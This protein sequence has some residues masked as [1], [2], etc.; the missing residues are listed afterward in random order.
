M[1]SIQFLGLAS[2]TDW[3]S[4]I[5]QL[6]E[7]ERKP[8]EQLITQ[9]S[10]LLFNQSVMSSVNTRLGKFD[11]MLSSLRF[12]STFLSRNVETSNT[13]R[14][15]A[16]AEAG[17]AIGT[18]NVE[19]SRL[20]KAGRAASG[21][22][23]ELYSKVANISTVQTMGIASLT[24]YGD[25]QAT[26]ALGSTLIKDTVQAGRA[27]AVITKGDT[28]SISG[29][30][31]DSTAVS[32]TFTFNGD[33]T[34]TLERLGTTIAQIFQ[35]EIAA[36]VGTDGEIV[37][38]ETDP[39]IAGD[40]T[41]NTTTP[42]L[43]IAFNDTDFSGSTLVFT[44]GNNVAGGPAT[45]RR[46][47]GTQTFTSAGVLETNSAT[48]LATLDQVISGIL[49]VGDVI[50][51]TGTESGGGAI[52]AVDFSYTGAAGGQTIADLVAAISGA[53]ITADATYENGKLVLTGTASGSS[54]ISLALEFVD[55]GGATEMQL[56]GFSVAESGRDAKAQMVTTGG[57]TVEGTGRHLLSSTNGRA[58]LIHGGTLI[59]DLSNTL[60]SHLVTEFDMLTIDVDGAAGGISPVT[61]TGL[62]EYS[63]VQDLI[64]AINTQVPAVTAQLV[65]S[66]G[67]YLL[68]LSA[69]EG[70]KDIRIYDVAGGILDR[71]IKAA[72][73][74][75][76]SATNDTTWTFGATT[77]TTE[78][79]IVDWFTPDNG[80]PAQRR[81][82]IGSEGG[83]VIGLIGGV[84]ING[85]GGNINPGIASIVT[86]NSAELN[87][88]QAMYSY[89]FGSNQIAV[90]PATQ[91]P[92]LNPALT[93]AQAGFATTPQNSSASPNFHTDGFFTING[94]RINVGDVDVVT[95]NDVLATINSS[96]AGV[97]ATFDEANLRFLLRAN[98][99]GASSI[100]LGGGGDTSNF[101][102]LA[103]LTDTNGGVQVLGQQ[104]GQVDRE[105]PLAQ[106]GFTNTINSGIFTINGTHIVIDAGV[107]SLNDVIRKINNS[108]AGVTAS[109]DP[110]ADKLTLSQKLDASTTA[111]RITV[112]DAAD[113][114]SFL[115]AVQLTVNTNV[116]TFVGS[117]RET[118]QFI[119]DGVNYTRNS[120]SVDDVIEK[121]KL[122]LNALTDGP[123][124]V[125]I[126]ADTER[127]Q[128]ALLDFVVEYNTTMELLNAKPL[129]RQ[130][131]LETAEL[132]EEQANTMTFQQVEDYLS[133]RET[134]LTRQFLAQDTSIRQIIRRIQ[135]LI[136][137]PV[138]NDG[139]FESISQLGLTTSEVGAGVEAAA[140]SQ[141]RLL[142]PT[143]DR[144]T[145]QTLLE[146]NATLQQ[147]ITD[148]GEE[149]YALFANML[150]SRYT[151]AGSRDL[152]SGMPVTTELR[153][154]I[155]DG[156]STAEVRFGPGTY[157]QSTILNVINS[158]LN[159]AG[160][161]SSM[162]PYFDALNQLNLRVAKSETQSYL[163]LLD[164]SSGAD[165]LQSLLGW[166]PGIFFG[167]DPDLA[168]GIARRTRQYVQSI[169]GSGGIVLERI[170]QNGSYD[171][172]IQVYDDAISR[173]EE[174]SAEYEQRLREKFARLE[175]QLSQLQSQ[176]A[177]IEAAIAKMQNSSSGS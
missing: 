46:L 142:A 40:V 155:G 133:K 43:S 50:R 55:Q 53:F 110:V 48:D 59:S 153:F 20:A 25:F 31:K 73:T 123:E 21:L 84:A 128:T 149:L 114:S 51:I 168:G 124:S 71:L 109:Y 137:G 72:A 162:L 173:M 144:E 156:T 7:V 63:T 135:N 104:R 120:N 27:G 60:S 64:D 6:V 165:S 9:R 175:T 80:G 85:A 95:V 164:L 102:F 26:R 1:S 125:T 79:T 154:T 96:G 19:I 61:I 141:G 28:I 163:Q 99:T 44:N 119:V 41:F 11:T 105:L 92:A 111:F 52:T 66:G 86:A 101:L 42:P 47:V 56:G 45:T 108:G 49:D 170:K 107:D 121:V 116:T 4:I 106:A 38:I 88:Q 13:A 76:D 117:V 10:K 157:S 176:S 65:P 138:S 134:L 36:S 146:T 94:V 23:G 87:T 132:T 89:I 151:H 160:L 81:V 15:S 78:A 171:R 12:E 39:T 70:G 33:S 62:S 169:T 103:G 130:E 68:D 58:G 22:D 150:E 75:L 24:P 91:I 159:S 54:Q 113:T 177:A 82:W 34:D 166:Q 172:Q 122:A 77:S 115:E 145:L 131:R 5:N 143:S 37:L 118:A 67:S 2:G 158:Q 74:D 83:S 35:G 93:L 3:N 129:S 140:A 98:S 90:S 18:H 97:T 69:N 167:P 29:L 127:M 136:T 126:T 17:A 32:G 112:G 147:A 161:S 139:E 8:L 152:S 14:V 16:T 30:L 174:N 57:F 100:T 148:G